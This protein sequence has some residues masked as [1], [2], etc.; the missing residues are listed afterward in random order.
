MPEGHIE[1]NS[2]M[3][4][5]CCNTRRHEIWSLFQ[6]VDLN[7]A[8]HSYM[9]QASCKT[10]LVITGTASYD[11]YKVIHRLHISC[12]STSL[13][14]FSASTSTSSSP[15]IPIFVI[16][17]SLF[18]FFPYFFF[19]HIGSCIRNCIIRQNARIHAKPD[20]WSLSL[21]F[22]SFFS[23]QSRS[24]SILSFSFFIPFILGMQR[25]GSSNRILERLMKHNGDYYCNVNMFSMFSSFSNLH[26]NV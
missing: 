7:K 2:S 4:S 6:R 10:M 1:T 26:I 14:S 17:L 12:S 18:S 13:R 11:V 15:S 21:L 9:S 16:S 19:G 5:T 8:Q 22:R 3:L 25:F 20:R 23:F 24:F